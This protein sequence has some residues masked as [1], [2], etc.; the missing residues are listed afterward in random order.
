MSGADSPKREIRRPTGVGWHLRS[1]IGLDLVAWVLALIAANGFDANT[2]FS[3]SEL[4][5][6]GVAVIAQLG[7]GIST[8]LY[9]SGLRQFSFEG[10]GAVAVSAGATGIAVIAA[11]FL[12][13]NSARSGQI[14]VV[15]ASLTVCLMFGHRY[16]R[17]MRVRHLASKT[18]RQRIP[19]IIYGDGRGGEQA[20]S[21]SVYL[22]VA[23]IDNDPAQRQRRIG[24]LRVEGTIGDLA[25]VAERHSAT[26]VLIAMP[27]ALSAELDAHHELIR[28]AGFETL[29]MAPVQQLAGSGSTQEFMSYTDASVLRRG[30]VDIDLAAVADLVCGARVLVTGAGGSI[31][32]EL[33]RQLSAFEPTTLVSGD[34]PEVSGQLHSRV[35]RRARPR[36]PR[37]SISAPQTEPGLPRC[38][39]PVRASARR[40][41]R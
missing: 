33:F 12:I 22:P 5:L 31:G 23:M 40:S 10:T 2:T 20:S 8:G 14:I 37:R 9:R 3:G 16:A 38:S 25:A 32:S 41:R 28:S 27:S 24:G 4:M 29:I 39:P 36:P 18:A 1:V 34:R 13:R 26:T 35:G 21:S 30:I 7:L 15:A 17:E 11:E 6:A 19:V